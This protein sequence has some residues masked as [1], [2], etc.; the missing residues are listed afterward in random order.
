MTNKEIAQKLSLI[1]D[2]LDLKGAD[3][4]EVRAYQQ[5]ARAVEFQTREL[6]EV[7]KRGG[8]GELKK[9]SGIGKVISRNIE[10]LVETGRCAKLED[11]VKETPKVMIEMIEVPGLGPKT[12]KKLY[13][14]LKPKTLADFKSKIEDPRF[15]KKLKEASVLEKSIEKILRGIKIYKSASGR[16]LLSQALPVAEQ[17]IGE[18]ARLPEVKRVKY[19]GS[20]RRRKE[21]VGDV[22][23]ICASRRPAK[24]IERFVEME[25]IKRVVAKGENK[26]TVFSDQGVQIDLEIMPVK[27]WGSLMHH[28]TG[29]KEHNIKL[30]AWAERQGL[31]FSE[32]GY[33]RIKGGKVQPKISIYC[34]TEEKVFKTLK[35]QYIP[36]ELRE[37]GDELKAAA[38]HKIPRLIRLEDIK[39]DLQLHSRWSDGRQAILEMAQACKKRGYEYM[40]MSDHSSGLGISGGID[41]ENYK[42]YLQEID[43]VNKKIRFIRVLR[44]IEVN[45]RPDGSIDQPDNFL[46]KFE[47]V[48]AG[49][50]SS[51]SQPKEQ[52][53]RRLIKALQ[54]PNL[55]GLVHP[56]GRIIDR[57]P[58]IQADWQGIFREAVRQKKILEINSAPDRLDLKDIYI[59]KAKEMGVKFIINT[60]AHIS[61]QL[62]FMRFGVF[63]A[64]RGWLTK[65]DV[66]NTL[67]LRAIKK[68]FRIE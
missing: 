56:S 1:A 17:V 32:H 60:D 47:I 55:D 38:S 62:G 23:I 7:V 33:K 36:P 4:F 51:F 49:V 26:A 42:R 8:V 41:A 5:A 20:L 52:A 40:A 59:K 31:S 67:P 14:L 16:L 34:P 50:H 25:I 68:W 10:E 12:V 22:D 39:G 2:V 18:L 13:N 3:P 37:G 66:I 11:L 15:S 9:I 27:E 46:R 45:I 54:N 48:L 64:R 61:D 30:R 29:S 58:E 6:Y 24:V 19:V 65:E 28:F 53:T 57:R 63:Q 35:M 44:G 21:T 43:E